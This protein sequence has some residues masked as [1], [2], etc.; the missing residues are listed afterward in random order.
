MMDSGSGHGGVR[1]V[2]V[3]GND[4][5][6]TGYTDAL[7]SGFQFVVDEGK[8]KVW[9][10]ALT[11]LGGELSGETTLRGRGAKSGGTGEPGSQKVKQPAESFWSEE[12]KLKPLLQIF[13][14][15]NSAV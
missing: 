1:S 2:V 10:V 6:C 11:S 12:N 4:L 14:Q 13:L 7:D 3:D 5:L 9:K 15:K 8:V